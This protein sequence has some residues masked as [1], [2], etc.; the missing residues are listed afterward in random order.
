MKQ[1]LSL[2]SA[3]ALV[4]ATTAVSAQ[5]SFGDREP[6]F[7]DGERGVSKS[8][9]ESRGTQRF[10]ALDADGD[11]T[12]TEDEYVSRRLEEFDEA[13]RNGDGTLTR[14]ELRG[15]QGTGEGGRGGDGL[16]RS[17]FETRAR[18]AFD[19]MAEGGTVTEEAFIDLRMQA[20]EKADRD[21][22]GVLRRGE[23][24]NLEAMD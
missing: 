10:E 1:L 4:T 19:T 15:L 5:P 17:E 24:R 22:D 6:R 23:V 21:G 8:E 3:L 9:F 12:V 16:S 18:S 7:G 11:G 14:G 20:F 13:D 2:V